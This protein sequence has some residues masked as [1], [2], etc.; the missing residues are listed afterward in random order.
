SFGKWRQNT[1]SSRPQQSSEFTHRGLY[2]AS[3]ATTKRSHFGRHYHH[4]NTTLL[5]WP[6]DVTM[7]YYYNTL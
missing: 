6:Y 4:I 2:S 7:R 5:G 1:S 3:R